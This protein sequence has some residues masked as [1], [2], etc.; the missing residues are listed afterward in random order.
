M[1]GD[2]KR[3]D[4]HRLPATAPIFDSTLSDGRLK[5]EMRGSAAAIRM[6]RIGA[7]APSDKEQAQGQLST[8]LPGRSSTAVERPCPTLK[9]HSWPTVWIVG[10]G[11]KR[12]FVR[13]LAHVRRRLT[14]VRRVLLLLP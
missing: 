9:G 13:I 2:G 11:R 10:R 12:S 1:S 3:G 7:Q 6:I 4:G 14:P 8:P 5:V